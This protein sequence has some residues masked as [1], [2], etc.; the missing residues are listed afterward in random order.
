MEVDADESVVKS[1]AGNSGPE[2]G[3][4]HPNCLFL[5]LYSSAIGLGCLLVAHRAGSAP[6]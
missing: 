2:P 5:V 6:P 1:M 4:F 3:T